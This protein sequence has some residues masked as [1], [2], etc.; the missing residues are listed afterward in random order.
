MGVGA[1]AEGRKRKRKKRVRWQLLLLLL[2]LL[3]L[4][5][6]L[7]WSWVVPECDSEGY[8]GRT[9][10]RG[11]QQPQQC[12]RVGVSRERRSRAVGGWLQPEG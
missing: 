11:V 12:R 8:R 2:S 4:L 6:L 9:R 5:L 10:P 3:L 7:L 1:G